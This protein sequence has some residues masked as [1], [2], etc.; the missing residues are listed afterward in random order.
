MFD[1]DKW[2]E[3]F[4]TIR[5]NKLRTILTMFGVFWG[6]FMLLLLLGGGSGLR[7]G[8]TNDFGN[9]AQNA[10]YMWTQ[11]TT[12]PYKGFKPGRRFNFNNADTEYLRDNLTEAEV[13]TPR[14]QLGGYRDANNVTRKNKAGAFSIYADYP[15]FLSIQFLTFPEGRFINDLDIQ[16]KR[17]VCVIGKGVR[18]ILFEEG[19]QVIGEYIKINGV[20]F[21]VIGLRES[22]T[23]GDEQDR[24]KQTIHIPFTTFQNV[25]NYGDVVGWFSMIPR[26]GFSGEELETRAKAILAERHSVHPN[27]PRAIGSNNNEEEY[28]E[29]MSL[30]A[31][32]NMFIWIVGIGTLTA[33]VIGVS[34]IMLIIVKE[35]TKEIGI[36]KSMGATP[37][38][39]ITLIIQESIF[40]TVLAGYGGLLLGTLLVET[41]N[42]LLEGR[43]TGM[44]ASPEID[45]QV[46]LTALAILV[47]GG[48]LAGLIPARKAASVNP[49]EALRTE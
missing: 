31:G 47:V 45:L 40:I 22:R 6:I 39:I 3:I 17:K 20:Y 26:E 18:D 2:Q 7:N 48:A 29:I 36:R 44:F 30:F 34:N 4:A 46:A 41:I 8:V 5:K 9:W 28:R 42:K 27:D 24:D 10:V 23:E 15:E 37:L 12:M 33:G 14:N 1:I 43:D 32:I 35:R 16:E 11:R 25:F 21:K 49:I 13:V 19:E 38:A